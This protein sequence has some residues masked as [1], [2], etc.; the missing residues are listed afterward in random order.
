MSRFV[1]RVWETGD[2]VKWYDP[3]FVPP[4]PNPPYPNGAVDFTRDPAEA[5]TFDSFAHGFEFWRQESTSIPVRP[6]G[7]PNRPLTAFGIECVDIATV[8]PSAT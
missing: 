5:L 1:L 7:R 8:E 2:L 4:A 3:D 6:D